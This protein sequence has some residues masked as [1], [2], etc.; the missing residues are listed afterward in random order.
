MVD[1]INPL[2]AQFL[3]VVL[4]GPITVLVA[5][6]LALGCRS[7]VTGFVNYL[8]LLTWAITQLGLVSGG[9]QPRSL[10]LLWVVVLVSSEVLHLAAF[11]ASNVFT[12]FISYEAVLIPLQLL[13]SHWGSGVMRLRASILFFLYTYRGSAPMLVAVLYLSSFAVRDLSA[14]ASSFFAVCS[15]GP[16]VSALWLSFAVSFAVKT[17]L[18]PF[19]IWLLLAHAEA[20]AEGSIILAGVVLKLATFGVVAVLLGML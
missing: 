13:I 4:G 15:S 18:Y 20:P 12:F 11:N 5:L 10:Q 1:P 6:D 8:F 7:P 14:R 17:P 16:S 2:G 19:F 9:Y 3:H